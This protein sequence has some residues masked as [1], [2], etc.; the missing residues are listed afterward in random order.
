ML[1]PHLCLKLLRAGSGWSLLEL[2]IVLALMAII[3]SLA[4]PQ[5]YATWQLQSLYDERQRLAQQIRFARL[6]SLQK[7]AKVSLCWS[8]V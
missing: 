1:L 2:L 7:S 8:E 5:L 3:A 6:S 4:A